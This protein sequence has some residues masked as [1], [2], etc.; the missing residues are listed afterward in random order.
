MKPKIK[1]WTILLLL[2]LGYG[3]FAAMPK[4]IDPPYA[5]GWESLIS[6]INTLFII[7]SIIVIIGI[8]KRKQWAHIII[9][10]FCV[11]AIWE[12]SRLEVF[13]VQTALHESIGVF[14]YFL[15][16]NFWFLIG[17]PLAIWDL[18][19]VLVFTEKHKT[20]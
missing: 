8:I 1:P 19:W 4:A 2:V 17:L 5:D 14:N 7:L 6:L 13:G 10:A 16:A 18:V 3:I 9:I 12:V 11:F 15:R 20:K